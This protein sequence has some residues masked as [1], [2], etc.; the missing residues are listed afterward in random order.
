MKRALLVGINTFDRFNS[1]QGCVNDVAALTPLLARNEDDSPNFSCHVL[2]SEIDRVDR[3]A[4]L[5]AMEALRAPG[6]DVPLFSFA[7]HG[8]AAKSDVIL[9]TQDGN[10]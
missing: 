5:E 7:S 9:V 8:D 3:H 4:L 2:T 6:A 10:E 1:L